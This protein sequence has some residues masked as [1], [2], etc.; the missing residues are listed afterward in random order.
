MYFE[1]IHFI[2]KQVIGTYN[3]GIYYKYYVI[4]VFQLNIH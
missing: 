2:D 1:H 4:P 3:I